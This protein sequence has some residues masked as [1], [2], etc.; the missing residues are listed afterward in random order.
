MTASALPLIAIDGPSGV[1]KS[2]TAKRAAAR[3]GWQYLDTGAMYRA[4]AL[5]IHRAGIEL[6]D[7]PALEGVLSGLDLSLNEGRTYLAGE[8]VSEAI[9]SQEVTLLVTPV[10]A[11]ARVRE[12]LVDQQRRI[13][14]RGRWVVDGRDIG[15]VVFTQACCK[16]FLT[17]SPEARAQ[18][19][20]L[21]LQ[22]KG[23]SPDFGAV[24]ADLQRRDLADSTRAASPLRKA[25]DA[26]ELDS[27][28]M[29]L[30]QV[31]D[32]IV[33]RHQAHP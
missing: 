29:S 6:T 26:V 33:A 7:R 30:D 24:L 27:S 13:G 25:E 17:A 5:A 2:T 21:E 18:R 32:W 14:N 22:A 8:D 11:D 31:V 3:L 10:S 15:T 4:A 16:V 28:G 1:G 12:V 23:Q 19:R 9:R 20:F